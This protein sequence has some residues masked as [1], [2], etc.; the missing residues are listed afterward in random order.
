MKHLIAF[1]SPPMQRKGWDCKGIEYAKASANIHIRNLTCTGRYAGVAIG[2]ELS[3]GVFNVTVEDVAFIRLPGYSYSC[4]G[5]GHIKWGRSRG[6]V[7]K[8]RSDD[9]LIIA[10]IYPFIYKCV[11]P[12]LF[13]FSSLLPYCDAQNITFRNMKA[14]GELDT[15]VLLDGFF[16]DPNPQCGED[17]SPPSLTAVS[18]IRFVNIDGTDAYVKRGGDTFHLFGLDD[19]PAKGLSF[20]NVHFGEG[21][22]STAWNCAAV[23][24]EATGNGGVSPW[25]PCADITEV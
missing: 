8:V 25:P 1:C 24:G 4:N 6:G 15:G 17:Y 18:D 9:I 2:S 21:P 13:N 3:G 10:S 23:Q 22:N 12:P 19:A 7:V 5:V 11:F 14:T 16:E 20:R